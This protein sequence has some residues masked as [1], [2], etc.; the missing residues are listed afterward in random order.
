MV[1][2]TK[3]RGKYGRKPSDT[4]AALDALIENENRDV[5]AAVVETA[6]TDSSGGT[7]PGGNVV[8]V[9]LINKYTTHVGVDLAPKA[10]F[11]TAV[12]VLDDNQENLRQLVNQLLTPLGL[13]TITANASST[14]G[15]L[16]TLAAVTTNL[17][18]VDGSGNDALDRPTA[19][20]QLENLRDNLGTILHGLNMA[21]V[22]CGHSPLL[23]D[24]LGGNAD[25]DTLTLVDTAATAA[26]VGETDDHA[27]DVSTDAALAALNDSASE[28]ADYRDLVYA[29][30]D[31]G[32]QLINL[33]P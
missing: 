7:A 13:T 33:V 25:V 21:A 8:A 14:L 23:L 30:A 16:G 22:A 27:D 24:T 15:V 32:H 26:G 10:G 28:I 12:G 19:N 17:T 29:T 6:I 1:T 4:N 9:N 11:D 18:A 3:S 20:D 5:L 2:V 31:G